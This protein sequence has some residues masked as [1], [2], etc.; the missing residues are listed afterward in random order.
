MLRRVCLIGCTLIFLFAPPLFGHESHSTTAPKIP[1]LKKSLTSVQ[2]HTDSIA[3]TFGPLDLPAP[4]S[5]DL[6]ASMPKHFFHLPEDRY[7]TGY[8]TE[9]FTQEGTP[10]PQE[11]LHHILLLDMDQESIS[12]PG[13]PLFFAGAGME[14]RETRFPGGHGVK[15]DHTHKLMALVAFYHKA[16]P[17]KNAMARFTI[18]TAP[19][20]QTIH[21]LEVYQVGVNVVCYSKFDQRPA[22]QSDEGIAIN[23]GVQVMKEPLKFL[24]DGCVK[25]AYPHG[26]NGALLIAL[27]NH[28]RQ[29]T[30]L[31]TVPDVTSDGAL[32]GFPD[33]QVYSDPVGFPI[34]TK[35]EYEMVLIHHRPLQQQGDIRGMGN[36]LLYMTREACP[37]PNGKMVNGGPSTH[38]PHK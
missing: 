2:V 8:K 29:Q 33:R 5:G 37:L 14:M 12:C 30:L 18:Y 34:S 19:K 26:H 28:T 22:N 9:A 4:H 10:L 38:S 31:R 7:M 15:L 3:I 1:T 11:Y 36:Y 17:T 27:E 6:A 16:A 13:E 35:E 20:G 23:P 21:P 32:L 24:V 25:F